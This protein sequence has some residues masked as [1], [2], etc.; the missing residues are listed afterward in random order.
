MTALDPIIVELITF[1]LAATLL[2]FALYVPSSAE[3]Q[4]R[5]TLLA[6][7]LIQSRLPLR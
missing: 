4:A 7:Q 2:D 3:D 1:D 5:L 6:V